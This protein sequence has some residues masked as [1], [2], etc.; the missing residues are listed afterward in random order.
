MRGLGKVLEGAGIQAKEWTEIEK[1]VS[2]WSQE[3]GQ[4][5]YRVVSEVATAIVA[6]EQPQGLQ[7]PA[8]LNFTY[9]TTV[10]APTPL[11][12]EVPPIWDPL[13]HPPGVPQRWER[14]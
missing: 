3:P 8:K 5:Q 1:Q 4:V 10:R 9:N 11:F 13:S 2:K 14:T 6:H 7:S 12:P